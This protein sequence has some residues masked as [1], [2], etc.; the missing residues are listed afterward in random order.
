MVLTEYSALVYGGRIS[1]RVKWREREADFFWLRKHITYCLAVY[2]P[3][4]HL[5]D[6]KKGGS[7]GE[8]IPPAEGT[9][10]FTQISADKFVWTGNSELVFEPSPTFARLLEADNQGFFPPH[11][12]LSVNPVIEPERLKSCPRSTI[13][14]AR[15]TGV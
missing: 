1:I 6:E 13:I 15:R 14:P 4:I 8:A 10:H 11:K 3:G 7:W 9:E 2:N 12:P 5:L